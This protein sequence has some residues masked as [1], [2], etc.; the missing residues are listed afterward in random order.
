M[1][2]VWKFPLRVSDSQTIKMPAGTSILCVQVQNDQPCIWA[3][4]PNTE[5]VLVS[6][7]ILMAGTGHNRPDLLGKNYIG[8]FQLNEGVLVFH[9][10]QS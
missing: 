7:T 4:V 6:Q 2:T 3:L 9:V 10:F 5:A 1:T 8:T